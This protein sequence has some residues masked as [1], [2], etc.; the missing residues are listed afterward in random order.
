MICIS[1][2]AF[3]A[4]QQNTQSNRNNNI[5][6]HSGNAERQCSDELCPQTK[7]E[8]FLKRTL[9]HRDFLKSCKLSLD[10]AMLR[11]N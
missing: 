4:L 6:E 3:I 5:R 11:L 2:I 1:E 10:K 7:C 9:T 8:P